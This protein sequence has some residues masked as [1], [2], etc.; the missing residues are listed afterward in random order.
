MELD[1]A[2]FEG[3]ITSSRMPDRLPGATW[4]WKKFKAST[5]PSVTA[6]PVPAGEREFGTPGDSQQMATRKG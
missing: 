4:E 5:L 2:D 1:S 3:K 6:T